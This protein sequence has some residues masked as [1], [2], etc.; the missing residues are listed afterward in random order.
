MQSIK[1]LNLCA[2]HDHDNVNVIVGRCCNKVMSQH[3]TGS[4]RTPIAVQETRGGAPRLLHRGGRGQRKRSAKRPKLD[5]VH[6]DAIR[7]RGHDIALHVI[8]P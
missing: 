8:V 4:V 5:V 1:L 2:D 6:V 7:R 3:E